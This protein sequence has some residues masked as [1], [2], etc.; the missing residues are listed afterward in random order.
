MIYSKGT[1]KH[2]IGFLRF[3]NTAL[4]RSRSNCSAVLRR[5]PAYDYWNE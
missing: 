3:A 5:G 4:L 2:D 1:V